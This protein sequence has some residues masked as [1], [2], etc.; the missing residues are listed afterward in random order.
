VGEK[1]REKKGSQ[2]LKLL[3]MRSSD[4]LQPISI[5]NQTTRV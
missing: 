2:A 5:L 4:T 3:L 1:E